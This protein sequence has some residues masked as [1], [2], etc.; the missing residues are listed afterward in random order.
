[1]ECFGVP[2]LGLN[3]SFQTKRVGLGEPHRVLVK[4]CIRPTGTGGR[5]GCWESHTRNSHVPVTLWLP[6]RAVLA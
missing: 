4:G 2:V 5:G 6:P 3:W 1:M